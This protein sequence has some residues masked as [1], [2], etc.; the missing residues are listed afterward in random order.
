M[1]KSALFTL[2]DLWASSSISSSCH[3]F[4]S[5]IARH[6]KVCRHSA[7][8]T[9]TF[10]TDD[11]ATTSEIRDA[12]LSRHRSFIGPAFKVMIRSRAE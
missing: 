12:I 10:G 8:D 9:L 1:F 11:S 4:S 3:P 5:P 6:V 7:N 2:F